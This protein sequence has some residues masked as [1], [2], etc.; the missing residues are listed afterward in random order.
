MQNWIFLNRECLVV[1]FL[2]LARYRYPTPISKRSISM[3][4][5]D[6][7]RENKRNAK[8]PEDIADL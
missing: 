3:S 8:A 1:K 7:D 5:E 2:T 6:Y 4:E